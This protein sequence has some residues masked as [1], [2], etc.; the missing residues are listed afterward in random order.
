LKVDVLSG[1]SVLKPLLPTDTTTPNV[2]KFL[3]QFAPT[4]RLPRSLRHSVQPQDDIATIHLLIPPPLQLPSDEIIGALRP[5]VQAEQLPIV[6]TTHV[7]LDPPTTADQAFLWSQIYWPCTFNPASQTIQRAPPLHLLRSTQV[8]FQKSVHLESYF[9]LA[10]TA[11]LECREREFGRE[12]AAVVVD[13]ATEEVVTVAGDARWTETCSELGSGE[14]DRRDLAE[15]RPEHHALM[16]AIAMVAEKEKRRRNDR[17]I[18]STVTDDKV[19]PNPGQGPVTAI[20]RLYTSTNTEA[21]APPEHF[22]KMAR[23][24][25]EERPEAYLC[26]GLDV[27]LTHEPCVACSMAMIHSRFRACIFIRRMPRTGGLCAEKDNGG[28]GYGLFWRSELN[29]RVLTFQYLPQDSRLELKKRSDLGS[30]EEDEGNF[31]A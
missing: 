26:N 9:N 17:E 2:H 28:L 30:S 22:P 3:R 10:Q 19:S 4:H 1:Y 20:E 12:I 23:A 5:F 21:I 14:S 7:P 27:Y 6:R 13:P 11:A 16:R 31:H 18:G 8:E 29:W 15:S 24:Q 25:S